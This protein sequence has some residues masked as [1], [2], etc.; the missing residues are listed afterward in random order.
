MKAG[1][2]SGFAAA[3]CSRPAGTTASE[4]CSLA[5]HSSAAM[6]LVCPQYNIYECDTSHPNTQKVPAITCD[7][8]SD[9]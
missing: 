8:L 9:M 5:A 3:W 2:G 1:V 7:M 4:H 6:Q